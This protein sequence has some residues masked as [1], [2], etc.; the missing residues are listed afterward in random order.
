MPTISKAKRERI[1]ERDDYTCTKCGRK[2][3]REDLDLTIDHIVPVALDGTG[4]ESNLVTM[5]QPCNQAKGGELPAGLKAPAEES[6]A[7]KQGLR[8]RFPMDYP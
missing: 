4:R 6:A 2:M 1:Y 5:C 7:L 8:D 3:R